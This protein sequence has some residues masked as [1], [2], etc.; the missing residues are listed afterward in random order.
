M[1]I[2]DVVSEDMAQPMKIKAVSGNDVTLDQGGQ[3]IKTTTDALAPSDKPGE[4]TMKP[5]DPN[6]MK[7]GA[8]VTQSDQQTSE[9]INDEDDPDLIG[10]GHNVD[11]GGDATD[12]F[13]N[14]VTDKDYERYARH[15]A[16]RP[17]MRHHDVKELARWK[18]I[19]GLE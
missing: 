3:E 2:S 10:S 16:D 9:E 8:N 11:V 13:I 14:D 17:L 19:A 12:D 6:T 1:K 5:A 4:F 15:G 18:R 7:P